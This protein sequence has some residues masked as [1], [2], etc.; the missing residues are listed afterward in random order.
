MV[1]LPPDDPKTRANVQRMT[2]NAL[3]ET[4]YWGGMGQWFRMRTAQ[5]LS[6]GPKNALMR[7]DKVG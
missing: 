5:V 1:P 7:G 2:P 3:V 6:I 4:P